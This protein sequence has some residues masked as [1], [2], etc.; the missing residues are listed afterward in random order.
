MARCI[1]DRVETTHRLPG[2]DR[3]FQGH[4]PDKAL[5]IANMSRDPIID[6]RRPFAVAVP[7][8]I[9]WW[10]DRPPLGPA[11]WSLLRLVDDAAYG[12]GVWAGCWRERSLAALRPDLTN[13]P[14]RKPAVEAAV[15]RR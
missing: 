15:I 4:R 1:G 2:D 3:T 9:E 8:L 7:P 12:A 6:G 5:D 13:W 10:H 11:T 14:G